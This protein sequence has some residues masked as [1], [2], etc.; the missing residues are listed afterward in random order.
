VD[1]FSDSQS[2][3]SH[4]RYE[5]AESSEFGTQTQPRP[6][7]QP[8]QTGNPQHHEGPSIYNSNTETYSTQ[9]QMNHSVFTNQCRL[10]SNSQLQYLCHFLPYSDPQ[11]LADAIT[12]A[13][14]ESHRQQ[15]LRQN[16]HHQP[17][18]NGNFNFNYN[19]PIQQPTN[20]EGLDNHLV[21]SVSV[22]KRK[23]E[24]VKGKHLVF[25]AVKHPRFGRLC[26]WIVFDVF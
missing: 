16:L 24:P 12:I 15:S 13:I 11:L 7:S 8:Q 4:E 17:L 19:V 23:R 6:P 9:T 20:A 2:P 22:K 1:E 25:T 5:Y 14:A 18:Q 21:G 10:T 26:S 3:S